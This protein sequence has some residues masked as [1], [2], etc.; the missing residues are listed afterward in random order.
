MN[1]RIFFTGILLVIA[2]TFGQAQTITESTETA[3]FKKWGIHAG[4][5]VTYTEVMNRQSGMLGGQ[6]AAIWNQRWSIGVAAYALNYDYR[7]ND[8]S[9]GADYRLEAGYAGMLVAFNH[10]L[11][12]R[13]MARYFIISAQGS[14]LYSYYDKE[15]AAE[16]PW[17]QQWPDRTTFAVLEPGIELTYRL[18]NNWWLGAQASYRTT[19]PVRMKGVEE[20]FLETWN[21]GLSVQWALF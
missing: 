10:H 18:H 8:L 11:S 15:H 16:L 17:Y 20:D 9:V 14:A 19:S 3:A 12:P 6:V 21:A 5:S 7:L 2:S 13:L 4:L 1:T